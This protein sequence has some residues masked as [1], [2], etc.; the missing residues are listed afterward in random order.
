MHQDLANRH[1]EAPSKILSKTRSLSDS[2]PQLSPSPKFTSVR[3]SMDDH[4][5]THPLPETPRKSGPGQLSLQLPSR[6]QL[7]NLTGPSSRAPL[8]PQVDTRGAYASPAKFIPRH[9][10]GLEWAR[11]CTTLHHST[12]AEQSSPDSSPIITQKG[13]NIPNRRMSVNS[14][15]IDPPAMGSWSQ[16]PSE[17]GGIASSLSSV[18]MLGSD[19][20]SSDS[21]DCDPLDMDEHDDPVVTTP[22]VHRHFNLGS[23][24]PV[25]IAPAHGAAGWLGIFTPGASTFRNVHRDRLRKK[26]SRHSSS[27]ASAANSNIASPV[28]ASPTS[29]GD[30]AGYFARASSRRES[31]SLG[32]SDLH[33]SSGNDS[34]DEAAMKVPSTP[35]VERR[36]VSRRGN[37]LPKPRAFGRIRAELQEEQMPVDTEVRREAE[38]IR[39]VR[40]NDPTVSRP[41]VSAHSSPI[42]QDVSAITESLG[43]IPEDLS[44]DSSGNAGFVNRGVA[45][46][47]GW[48]NNN[49]SGAAD[50]STRTPPPPMFPRANSVAYSEDVNMDSPTGSTP[51][52]T[53]NERPN[54]Y[55]AGT[56]ISAADG[57]R[58]N[59][60]RRRDDD[61]DMNSIKRRAVS[62]GLSV[63]N[64]PIMS[65]SPNQRGENMWGQS[66][67]FRGR[68]GSI[69][70]V[71]AGERSSSS[72]SLANV[73]PILGPKRIGLQG[74]TDMQ[75][76]T[77]KMS[78]E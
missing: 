44:L 32:T 50:A 2:A 75:G 53:M 48:T 58:K 14:M 12:L 60:K 23:S 28:P 36:V 18:N 74:M 27:S 78:I 54:G 25:P 30:T 13:M 1:D 26:R 61:L 55:P 68:E 77:E 66:S 71:H 41:S 34:G 76:L 9:S 8:S 49:W 39:Q 43:A 52:A 10:R 62:P 64:S 51:S 38:V 59:N 33:I 47:F 40:E 5:I 35:G 45:A 20:S 31:L 15:M 7:E 70:G 69:S 42:L 37:L 29:K 24:T 72:G 17:R 56:V 73:T 57:L 19:S 21:D 4:G 46:S 16:V 22:Q 3:Q 65:Q 63:T 6:E 11:A 67:K